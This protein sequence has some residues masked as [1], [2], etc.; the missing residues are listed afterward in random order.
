M[1]KYFSK[2]VKWVKANK[3]LSIIIGSSLLVV[4]ASGVTLAVLMSQPKEPEPEPKPI[5]VA[6]PEPEPVVYYSPLTGNEVK[7]EA[8]TK[9]PVTAIMIENSPDARPQSGLKDS[10]VVFE[11]IAEG[12]ITRFLG[13]YQEQKP[14]LVGPV[15]SLRM[16]Y[17]DWLAPFN[18]SV[19]HVGGSAASLKE[20]RNG[21]YRDIDQFFNAGTYWRA[22]DRYAPHNV[23]TNFDRI[24]KLN[25]AKGY[26]T[27]SFTGFSRKD[28][29]KA[30]EPTASKV[31]VN[32][33]SFL[34]NSSYTYDAKKNVYKRS[35]GGAPHRDRE[36]GQIT[37]SVVVVMKVKERMVFEDG[38][39]EQIDTIGSGKAY[40]FQDGKAQE[41]TWKKSARGKQIQFTDKNGEDVPLIRGQT[42]ITAIPSTGSVSWQ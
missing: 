37:P 20:I 11:A 36:A 7:D 39:R 17:V 30:K 35:Q 29:E 3:K 14:K 10:G 41:V 13:L 4:I 40:I 27:S 34:Y 1:K 18:A 25:R 2:L 42:W 21:K 19:A 38:W 32:I 12:G 16:Y 5:V 28:S 8:A 9:Q 26:K 31:T 24:D 22:T 15:R 6:E 33:S 23:Y